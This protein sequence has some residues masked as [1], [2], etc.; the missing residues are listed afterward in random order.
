MRRATQYTCTVCKMGVCV[1]R[2]VCKTE[3]VGRDGWR[4]ER[5]LLG[6]LTHNDGKLDRCYDEEQVEAGVREGEADVYGWGDRCRGGPT[7]STL[8][9]PYVAL[10][11]QLCGRLRACAKTQIMVRSWEKTWKK[12]NRE[13]LKSD[14]CHEKVSEIFALC[15]ESFK[16]QPAVYTN[17]DLNTYFL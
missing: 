15:I 9:W 5:G 12:S 17:N 13:L 4:W 2:W 16:I 3:A 14:S 10:T 11:Q 1:S 7:C 8:M 6:Q